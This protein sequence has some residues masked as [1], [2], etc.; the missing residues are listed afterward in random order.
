MVF[1][2]ASGPRQERWIGA[3]GNGGQRLFAFPQLDLLIVI[4]AGNYNR[5]DQGTPPIRVLTEVILPSLR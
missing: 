2:S 3:I 5:R 1:N 4:T